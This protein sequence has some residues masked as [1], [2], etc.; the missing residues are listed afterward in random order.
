M[1]LDYWIGSGVH[2]VLPHY[3]VCLCIVRIRLL[4]LRGNHVDS[5]KFMNCVGYEGS[6]WTRFWSHLSTNCEISSVI[7][8][9][10][11]TMGRI[12]MGFL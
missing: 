7:L 9:Q 4:M 2:F 5:I 12:H 6:L 11:D 1:H 10:L 3:E 8:L